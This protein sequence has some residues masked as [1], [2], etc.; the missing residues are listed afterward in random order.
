MSQAHVLVYTPLLSAQGEHT[1]IRSCDWVKN[2]GTDNPI[3]LYRARFQ[4]D[5]APD[6]DQPRFARTVFSRFNE[7][8]RRYEGAGD[9]FWQQVPSH[10]SVITFGIHDGVKLADM[11]RVKGQESKS[12]RFHWNGHEYKWKPGDNPGDISC[13]TVPLL[14]SGKLLATYTASDGSLTIQE[15]RG[16]DIMD[17]IV[18]LCTIHLTFM[19]FGQW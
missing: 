11:R 13:Y 19:S 3:A 1:D 7:R 4:H 14:G 18:V 15:G 17:Q 12:R 16:V 6:E 8:T 5:Q 9:I 2:T 10:Q